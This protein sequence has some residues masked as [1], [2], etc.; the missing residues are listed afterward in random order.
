[1]K[2]VC[3]V[4][5]IN[6]DLEIE[7]D[8]LPKNG[9]TIISKGLSIYCG[10]KGS[11]E[12]VSLKRNGSYVY[13]I[14]KIGKDLSGTKG[15]N[16][17]KEVGV[18]TEGVIIEEGLETG[19]AVIFLF[20][21]GTD[22]IIVNAGSNMDLTPK[23]IL[24][25]EEL[26]KSSDAVVS[27]LEIPEETALKA[28]KIAKKHKKMTIFNPSPTKDKLKTEI[29]KYTDILLP[30]KL[31][32]ETLTGIKITDENSL[33]SAGEIFIKGGAKVIVFILGTEGVFIYNKEKSKYLEAKKVKVVDATCAGDT[34][35]GSFTSIIKDLS[36]DEIY[37]GCTYGNTAKNI[38]IGIKGS[39]PSIP[40]K[41]EREKSLD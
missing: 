29:L 36:F 27:G 20:N 32:T 34:F 35:I 3:V 15:L 9:E 37:K 11:N 39:E 26:I 8:N 4:G 18:N 6:E 33:K 17:L 23:D 14:G 16:K 30:N 31:V 40:F 10:G 22:S 5:S 2:N 19:K 41:E 13:F 24:S 1:M 12:A 7:I 25:K 28:F 21:D 38:C